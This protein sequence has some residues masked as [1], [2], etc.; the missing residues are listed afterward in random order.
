MEHITLLIYILFDFIWAKSRT[1]WTWLSVCARPGCNRD[2][3]KCCLFL[4][5]WMRTQARI[6]IFLCVLLGVVAHVEFI[7][8]MGCSDNT[9]LKIACSNER[10]ML[11]SH[12]KIPSWH[13]QGR[14]TPSRTFEALFLVRG[15]W[16]MYKIFRFNRH[17]RNQIGCFSFFSIQ[18][19]KCTQFSVQI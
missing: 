17:N 19:L 1:G 13:T 18:M 7:A 6:C 15:L 12:A 5:R 4:S 2:E 9:Q 16:C 8:F 14:S 10:K 11:A 3:P